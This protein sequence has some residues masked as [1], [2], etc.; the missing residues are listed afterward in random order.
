[1][2]TI[3]KIQFCCGKNKCP[4]VTIKKDRILVGG[5]KEGFSRFDKDQ[6]SD[7]IKAAKS[8]AFDEYVRD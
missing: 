5:K 3:K 2:S 7:L 6:F 4:E 8:G 1:M